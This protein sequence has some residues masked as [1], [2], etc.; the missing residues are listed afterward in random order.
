MSRR[1]IAPAVLLLAL[2][3]VSTLTGAW[4]TGAGPFNSDAPL[5]VPP[6]LHTGH[7]VPGESGQPSPATE[8][9][10]PPVLSGLPGE[11]AVEALSP[12][13]AERARLIV[14]SWE[15][16]RYGQRVMTVKADGTATMMIRPSGLWATMFGEQIDLELYWSIKDGH[17]DYGV[18]GG[19]SAEQV[20]T[21]SKMW[22]DHWIEKIVTLTEDELVLLDQSTSQEIG[23]KRA[24]PEPPA[25]SPDKAAPDASKPD[26]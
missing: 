10:D 18:S 19:A 7:D 5:A 25:E 22:G 16:E 6:S 9:V 12:E 2:I 23:W 17:I 26:A 20:A 15:Q 13:D 14:G 3:G 1:G 24:K 11:P 4:V 21:A 8:V